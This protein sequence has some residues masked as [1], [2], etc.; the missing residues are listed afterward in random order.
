MPPV[1]R[2]RF[3]RSTLCPLR[4]RLCL[5]LLLL[6]TPLLFLAPRLFLAWVAGSVHAMQSLPDAEMA[7]VGAQ[8]GI[9]ITLEFRIN[10]LANG[11]PDPCPAVADAD[12]CRLALSGGDRRGFWV[13]MKDY[14]GII[15][16]NNTRI[17]ATDAPSATTDWTARNSIGT[18]PNAYLGVYNPNSKPVIQLTSGP[19]ATAYAN[20]ATSGAY[21]G[22]LNQASYVDFTTSVN[23]ARLTAE[24]DCGATIDNAAGIHVGGCNASSPGWD[25]VDRVPGYLRNAVTGA[26]VS[27]RM[28]TGV[29]ASALQPTTPAQIRL[30]GRLQIYGYG[31]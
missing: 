30:D 14:Y 9:A 15:K 10:A 13:V 7:A 5:P 1:F 29:S 8:A 3:S 28:A 16:L 19:W 24:Y 21:Y 17:D 22:F 18:S 4:A 11:D 6:R 26:P 20:G 23:I 12:T 2:S 27:L 25:G 31:Y